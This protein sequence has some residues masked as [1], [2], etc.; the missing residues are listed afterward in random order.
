MIANI[1]DNVG[2][3]LDKLKEWGSG[4][5]H[6]RDF[7]ERQRRHRGGQV[8]QRGNAGAEGDALAGG[9]AGLVVLALAGNA[10]AGRLRQLAAH[11]DFLPTL[12]E[13]AGVKL[14]EEVKKQVE[15]RSLWPLLRTRKPSGPTARCS[16]MSGAGRRGRSSTTTNTPG[17]ASVTCW[18]LVSTDGAKPHGRCGR[19]R[20]YPR[21]RVRG[22]PRGFRCRTSW[23]RVP[24]SCRQ[25]LSSLFQLS[26]SYVFAVVTGRR[27]CTKKPTTVCQ[28]WV[29]VETQVT[30]DKRQRRRQLRRRPAAATC[31]MFTNIGHSL[32]NYPGLVKPPVEE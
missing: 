15:G 22:R 16:R 25:A 32:V 7:H 9:H 31:R 2:R 1:D 21:L 19:R 26:C 23:G 10:E 8:F 17:A 20:S 24:R 28:P 29:L 18:H 4:K 6:A 30:F 12:A 13:I 5:G 14:T 3:L 11:I 27:G